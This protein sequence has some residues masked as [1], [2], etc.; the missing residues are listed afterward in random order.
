MIRLAIV[1]SSRVLSD[2]LA[3]RLGLEPDMRVVR[4]ASG[5]AALQQAVRESTADVVLA[6]ARLFDLASV[7]TPAPVRRLAAVTDGRPGTGGCTDPAGPALVLLADPADRDML[8][9]AVRAGVRGWVP[10]SDSVDRL[11]EVVRDISGGGTRIP[12]AE[13]S[14][15]LTELVW[16]PPTDP[17]RSLL[18]SLSPREHEVLACLA[19][20]MGR[21]EVAVR[22]T[23]STNTVRTHVQRILSKLDVSSS[24]AAVAIYRRSAQPAVAGMS[25]LPVD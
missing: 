9:T 25:A 10:Y 1:G 7:V 18:D 4:C 16:S 12:P 8:A 17:A 23:L 13:L 11:I 2:A 24:L 6:E 14:V 21:S 15:V 3:Y 20:G 22:L 19:E 5:P